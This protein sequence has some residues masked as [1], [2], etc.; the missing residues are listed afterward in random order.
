[1]AEYFTNIMLLLILSQLDARDAAVSRAEATLQA[2]QKRARVESDRLAVTLERIE[3]DAVN[4]TARQEGRDARLAQE[5][6]RLEALQV[7]VLFF[8]SIMTEYFAN[9][10]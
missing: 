7:R 5:H 2:E 9:I 1:M 3:R 10:M 6:A 8:T 4:E